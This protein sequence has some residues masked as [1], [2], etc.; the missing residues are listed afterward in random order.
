MLSL[1]LFVALPFYVYVTYSLLLV[2]SPEYTNKMKERIVKRKEQDAGMRTVFIGPN[3]N[4]DE[5]DDELE[6]KE[7]PKRES[8]KYLECFKDKH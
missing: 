1:L 4:S 5:E 6:K 7:L 8:K 2:N 3:A